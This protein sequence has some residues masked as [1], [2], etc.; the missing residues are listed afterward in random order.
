MSSRVL[1]F[2]NRFS[3]VRLTIGDAV[4]GA[5]MHKAG[6]EFSN[7]LAIPSSVERISLVFVF[8]SNGRTCE[9]PQRALTVPKATAAVAAPA[10]ANATAT[11]G[12]EPKAE[13]S[14][15][16]KTESAPSPAAAEQQT[17]SQSEH[18]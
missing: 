17:S 1:L 4:S 11:A 5:H 15:A 8:K 10:S 3:A 9:S 18:S 7:E 6:N 13:L 14:M 2:Q 16:A 12:S